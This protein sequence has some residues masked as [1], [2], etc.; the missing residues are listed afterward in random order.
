MDRGEVHGRAGSWNSFKGARPDWIEG[1]LLANL[2]VIGPDREPDIPDVP[3]LSEYVKD[4]ADRLIAVGPQQPGERQ[5]VGH[6]GA[7]HA[8]RGP[9]DPPGEAAIVEPQRPPFAIGKVKEW[10]FGFGRPH[11]AFGRAQVA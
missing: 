8:P 5:V 3:L 1:D 4:P 10:K 2:A 6:V 11:Q 9:E 7:R